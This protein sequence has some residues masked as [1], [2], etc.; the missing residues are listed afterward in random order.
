M[1]SA[2]GIIVD[3]AVQ[4]LFVVAGALALRWYFAASDQAQAKI[5]AKTL[6]RLDVVTKPLNCE[7]I[8]DGV[9]LQLAAPRSFTAEQKRKL[10]AMVQMAERIA[11]HMSQQLQ[12]HD[13]AFP[14]NSRPGAAKQTHQVTEPTVLTARRRNPAPMRRA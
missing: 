14:T 3:T 6:A 8:D 5:V 9:V 4:L 10:A 2:Y 13:L 1:D 11:Q 7:R 12:K